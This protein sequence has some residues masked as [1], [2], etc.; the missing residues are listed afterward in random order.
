MTVPSNRIR[1]ML[2]LFAAVAAVGE[3]VPTHADTTQMIISRRRSLAFFDSGTKCAARISSGR[4]TSDS[5][6][7]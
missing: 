1:A 3:S 2:V 6:R 5:P 7:W 4:A